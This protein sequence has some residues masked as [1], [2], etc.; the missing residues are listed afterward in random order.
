MPPSSSAFPRGILIS[1]LQINLPR[2]E[3]AHLQSERA[4]NFKV[5]VS[6]N[7]KASDCC[8]NLVKEALMLRYR[9]VNLKKVGTVLWNGLR[10]CCRRYIY[11]EM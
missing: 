8:F 2:V 1:F 4:K 10:L 3:A 5:N 9:A 6:D 11:G 7:L